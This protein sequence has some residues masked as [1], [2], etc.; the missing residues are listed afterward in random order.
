[1]IVTRVRPAHVQ[2]LYADLLARCRICTRVAA[3]Q[4]AHEHKCAPGLSSISVRHLHTFLRSAFAWAVRMQILARNPLDAIAQDVPVR[5]LPKADAFTDDEIRA[6][7][8]AAHETRW[9]ATIMLALATGMRRGELAALRW[10]D[11]TIATDTAGVER[12]SVTISRAFAQ[13]RTAVTLKST[14]TRATRTIPLSRLGLDALQRQRFRQSSDAFR[15]E[16]GYVE[17]GY[18]FTDPLGAPYGPQAF[19]LAFNRVRR[20]AGVR[21]RLHDA[22]HT[23]ASQ[24]LAAGVDVRTASGLLGHANPSITLNIYSHAIAGLKEEAIERLDT[25]LR[26]AIERPQAEGK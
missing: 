23:A 9:D 26:A 11:V 14:K 19:T 13:T 4:P 5:A 16:S 8:A 24:L 17:S 25:R 10:A 15:A 22:R 7:L 18:V 12:G 3:D 2:A 1:L 20:T 21:K 6:L